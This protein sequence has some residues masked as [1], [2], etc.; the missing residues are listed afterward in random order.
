MRTLENIHSHE[1]IGLETKIIESSNQQIIGLNGTVVDETKSMFTINTKEGLKKI[2]K[3]INK[4]KFF[5]NKTSADIDGNLLAKR[6]Q[7]RL[8]VKA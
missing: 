8:G 3:K 7:D 1:I 2:P 6:P 5:F 4:W